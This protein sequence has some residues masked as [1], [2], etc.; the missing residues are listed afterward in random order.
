MNIEIRITSQYREPEWGKPVEGRSAIVDQCEA[1]NSLDA[2]L[3]VTS[4][5]R[6]GLDGLLTV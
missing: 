3:F 6:H 4:V 2:T 5:E 1:T